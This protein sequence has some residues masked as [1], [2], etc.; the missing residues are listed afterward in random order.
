[1]TS[2]GK[3]SVSIVVGNCEILKYFFTTVNQYDNTHIILNVRKNCICTDL[4]PSRSLTIAEFDTE[5]EETED[6]LDKQYGGIET[7][8]IPELSRPVVSRGSQ[9]RCATEKYSS[10]IYFLFSSSCSHLVVASLRKTVRH[11]SPQASSVMDFIFCRLDSSYDWVGT[12]HSS[13]HS[14]FH[15]RT[16]L[17]SLV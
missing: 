4:A 10:V 5:D 3:I 6:L 17:D 15:T 8:D 7:V 14:G 2:H 9:V 13:L 11:N 12:V 1:M 16:R